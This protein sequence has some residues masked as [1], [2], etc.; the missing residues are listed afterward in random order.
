MICSFCNDPSSYQW[1]T[2]IKG[3][4]LFGPWRLPLCDR[5]VLRL[6]ISLASG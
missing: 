1:K 3:T 2:K 5:H 6:Y 4:L